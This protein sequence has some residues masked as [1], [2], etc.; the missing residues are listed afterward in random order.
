M[1]AGQILVRGLRRRVRWMEG[2]GVE[3]KR[4]RER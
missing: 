2:R 4:E 1:A 3:E